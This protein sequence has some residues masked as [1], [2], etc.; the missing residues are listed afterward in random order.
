MGEIMAT[1]S[2]KTR[3]TVAPPEDFERIV[4]AYGRGEDAELEADAD[5]ARSLM[6]PGTG[7]FRD[8]SY[9]APSMPRFDPLKCVGCMECVTACPDS[10]FVARVLDR[11]TVEAQ[12]AGEEPGR[13]SHLRQQFVE[14][15]KYFTTFEK[16]GERGGLFG[17]AIDPAKCKG[18]GECVEVCGVHQ[19]LEMQDKTP[20]IIEQARADA[21]FFRALPDTPE[22][23]VS[24]KAL[25]DFMLVE[26]SRLYTG[27][28]GSCM[29]CGEATAI[30]MML[31]ATGFEYGRENIGIV[32]A[33]GCNTVYGSTYPYNPYLV[34]WTN[35][36]FENA[37]ADAMGIRLRWD[38]RG[39]K[40]KRLWVLGG[41]G[42][43]FDIGFG[44]LSRL[45]VSGLDVKVLVLDSQV[46][47]NTGG[48]ASG[49]SFTAQDSKMA[50]YG[51]LGR[52]KRER[53]K[54]LALLAMMHPDVFVAQ[55][56]TAD[57]N[58]FY[59][60]VMAANSYP[61]PAV[62]NVYTACMPEH[63]IGDDMA[64]HQARLAR[65]SRA[66]PVFVY[67]PRAGETMR[68]R[69]RLQGNPALHE[70]WYRDPKTGEPLDFIAFART[71]GRFA[72]HFD[73]EGRPDEALLAAQEER[74]R[75]W[76]LLQELAG[77]R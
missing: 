11:E 1:H 3:E 21:A 45:L 39:W 57:P 12:V 70:D 6:P 5:V 30:R 38:Q 56:I 44:S 72:R 42:A 77:I 2:G 4:C 36:L 74:L 7:A 17:L 54:E 32:A 52:G 62:I 8:F 41:D 69:L 66:F 47:S 22:R 50:S 16:R 67:E 34:T 55:T 58:H 73:A 53:R 19:A 48:Q 63:G 68:Q 18:C 33:T 59:R 60:A 25:V 20:A 29:G 49:A 75:N 65:D 31:A 26:R 46:Y 40:H 35:S 51:K 9:I 43:M 10:A 15:Q 37:P 23:Y 14:T 61:G 27:G 76:R 24:S 71:E 13:R 28:A 64:Q